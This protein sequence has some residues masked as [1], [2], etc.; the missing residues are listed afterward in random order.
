MDI[1]FYKNLVPV[2]NYSKMRFMQY[3]EAVLQHGMDMGGMLEGFELSFDLNNAVGPQLDFIADYVGASRHF[4]LIP[5]PGYDSALSDDTFRIVIQAKI[6]Q[7]YW[8]GTNGSF[9]EIWD[10]TIGKLF[11][12]EY[13]DNQDMSISV[14]IDGTVE[15]YMTELILA[16]KIIPKPAGVMMYVTITERSETNHGAVPDQMVNFIGANSA[17]IGLHPDYQAP[18]EGTDSVGIGSAFPANSAAIQIRNY[19]PGHTVS[20]DTAFSGS[21][22][23]VNEARITIPYVPE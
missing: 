17:E 9:Q 19:S 15:P 4:P 6:M 2:K 22:F 21:A 12:A 20:S 8:D 10:D 1:E 11:Q 23:P 18:E 14:N 13:V 5:I 16:G 7:N 3:L